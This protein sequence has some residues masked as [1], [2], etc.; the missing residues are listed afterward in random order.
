M[1]NLQLIPSLNESGA[2]C[3]GAVSAF[4]VQYGCSMSTGCLWTIS[5]VVGSIPH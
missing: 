4:P 1:A 5:E 3:M 2:V